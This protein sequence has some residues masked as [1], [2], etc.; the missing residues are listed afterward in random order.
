MAILAG[1]VAQV[2]EDLFGHIGPFQGA[3]ALTALALLLVLRWD[4][5]YGEDKGHGKDHLQ[6]SL[7]DQ[8]IDGWKTTIS[9]SNVWRIGMTQALSEGAMY[10]VSVFFVTFFPVF[11]PSS[12]I[13][14][15]QLNT[16]ASFCVRCLFKTDMLTPQSQI[17]S[18]G[19]LIY[20]V[21]VYVG[22]NIIINGS[23]RWVT[24]WLCL[25]GNDDGYYYG[26]GDVPTITR[27]VWKFTNFQIKGTRTIRII[28]LLC[29]RC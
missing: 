15:R 28:Y 2:L 8:F 24:N 13:P 18:P 21:R 22:T 12:C 27:F 6:T 4:E 3:I 9:N 1:I 29:R 20:L 11:R 10:T 23:T 7:Y 26:R 25:F 17:L 16:F 19:N 5:N 14:C